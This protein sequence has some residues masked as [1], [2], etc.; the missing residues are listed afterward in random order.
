MSKTIK[1]IKTAPVAPVAPVAVAP[2][3]SGTFETRMGMLKN[4]RLA[5]SSNDLKAILSGK[6]K[7]GFCEKVNAEIDKMGIDTT[8]I[9]A[10]DRNPKVIKRFIQCIYSI[11]SE[12]VGDIDITTATIIY[13]LHLAGDNPLTI[14]ALHYIGAG[15]KSGKVSPETKGV[16]RTT[17]NK[18]FGRVGLS[19]IPTQASRTVGKNGFLQLMG[20][21]TGEPG[22]QNQNVRLNASHPLIVK[23]FAVMNKATQGQIDAMVGADK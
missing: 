15:L 3:N 18:I 10:V 4:H 23:F 20:A 21:T 7:F 22:K 12:T 8:A 2:A 5:K 6:G 17:V 14:D 16:N 13:A 11:G 1:T 9:F 19:T